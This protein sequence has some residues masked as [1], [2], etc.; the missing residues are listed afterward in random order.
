MNVRGFMNEEPGYELSNTLVEK[1]TPTLQVHE[2]KV[3]TSK[4]NLLTIGGLGAIVVIL[5]GLMINLYYQEQISRFGF[6]NLNEGKAI[7]PDD[8]LTKR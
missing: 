2:A 5:T 7:K 8:S 3:T 1:V 6:V 4:N